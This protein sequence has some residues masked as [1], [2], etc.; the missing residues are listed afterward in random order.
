ME[1]EG[2]IEDIEKT[3]KLLKV[4]DLEPE[5]RGYSRLT[6]KYGKEKKSGVFEA[7]FAKQSP[8]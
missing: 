1:I 4:R 5:P 6:A 2:A 7:R 3:E 8:A